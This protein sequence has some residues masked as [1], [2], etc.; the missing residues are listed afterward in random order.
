MSSSLILYDHPL[1]PY[2]QKVRMMLREK[3]LDFEIRVP[4][5]LGSGQ[6]FGY[7]RH[8]PRL[9]IPSLVVAQGETLFDSSIIMEYLEEAHPARPMLPP[10]PIARARC[11]EV[12]EICDT[13]Y[14]AI[15]W[16]LGEIRFFARG[17]DRK[18]KLHEVAR[19]EIGYLQDWL[20]ARLSP[21]GWLSGNAFG[22]ADIAAVPHVTMSQIFGFAPAPNSPLNGWLD[23]VTQRPAVAV[24][25]GEAA[26]A[27]AGMA[28]YAELLGAGNFNRQFRDHRLEWMVR[29][30]GIEIVT[31]G[32]ARGNI[33][34]T[35]LGLFR[36]HRPGAAT[37]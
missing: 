21:A 2:T 28:Q 22:W 34:F 31:E 10:G 20:V 15:N 23:R 24:T 36:N 11:R 32:L 5:G 33:R 30:G 37:G 6:D 8:N 35:D 3:E 7:S 29:A 13:L 14:E 18:R 25:L 27:V 4:D 9:E 12:E 16:G 19:R 1:S 26:A 17:A